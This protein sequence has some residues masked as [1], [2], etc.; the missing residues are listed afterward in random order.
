MDQLRKDMRG[1]KRVFSTDTEASRLSRSGASFVERSFAP[2]DAGPPGPNDERHQSQDTTR[3][4]PVSPARPNRAPHAVRA[5]QK[6]SPRKLLRRL[7]AADEVD[8]ELAQDT[9]NTSLDTSLLYAQF[10]APPVMVAQPA[11]PE[12]AISPRPSTRAH[13]NPNLNPALLSAPGGLAPAYPSSSIRERNND[14]L[15]RF[16]SSS[17]ASGTTLT[18]GSTGSFVKHPGPAQIT[19][20]APEDVPV[21]PERVGR[22]VFDKVMMRWVKSTANVVQRE[23]NGNDYYATSIEGDADSE[24]PFRDIESLREDESERREISGVQVQ[25]MSEDPATVDMSRMDEMEDDEVIEDDELELTSFSFDGP[26]Q[27]AIDVNDSMAIAEDD[28][29]TDSDNDDDQI[30]QLTEMSASMSIDGRHQQ[31]DSLISDRD[32]HDDTVT[33]HPPPPVNII[34]STPGRPFDG[35]P[36][37]HTASSVPTPIRSAL[38]SASVTPVSALKDNVRDKY[39]TPANKGHRRSVSFSD[40]KRDGQIR[41]LTRKPIDSDASGELE[42]EGD[43]QFGAALS[44]IPS[45]RSKR[46]ADMMDGLEDSMTSELP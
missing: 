26:S 10:P 33:A 32:D 46:I 41:G 29:T 44:F 15:N 36:L 39:E 18:V 27:G 2:S 6:A 30:T 17:T 23:D 38:K 8:R 1:N 37:Q 28:E 21:L 11:S 40:G 34:P 7:S 16:V 13:S 5:K 19:R 24:D 4:F 45:A 12:R 31:E 9:S 25:D 35:P 20:I 22:M 3:L 43:E 14:D 42:H